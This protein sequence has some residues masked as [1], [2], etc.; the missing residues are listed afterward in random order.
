MYGSGRPYVK[1]S[2]IKF[3]LVWF[4]LQKPQHDEGPRLVRT[5]SL[6]LSA[7]WGWLCQMTLYK[8]RSSSATTTEESIC[9]RT[10]S[11]KSDDSVEVFTSAHTHT[12]TH[13]NTHTHTHKHTHTHT[14]QL[15]DVPANKEKLYGDDPDA[16]LE[17]LCT[18]TH[19]HTHTHTHAHTHTTA[20]R[21]TCQQ[22]EAVWR[23][24]RHTHTHAH[25]HTTAARRP[26]QQGKAVWR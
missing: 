4:G 9:I 2:M 5:A 8:T 10:A 21:R 14:S 17:L 1:H 13:T 15:Q 16:I 22:G 11:F 26:C 12:H 20:A 3:S 19:F 24:P 18:H 7:L 23:R 6:E 25:T